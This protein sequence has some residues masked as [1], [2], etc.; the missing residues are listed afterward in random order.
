MLRGSIARRYAEAVFQIG[1]ENNAVDR[2]RDDLRTI[3]EYYG[4]KRLLFVLSEP[5]I[6][7]QRKEQVV[8]DLLADKVQPEAL[9]LAL[10]LVERELAPLG[11][12]ISQAFD[13]RFNDYKGIAVAQVTTAIP[14]DESLRTQIRQQLSQL[15]GKQIQLQERVSPD[16]LG[17]AIAR[18]GDTLIDGSLRRRFELLRQQIATGDLGGPDDGLLAAVLGPGGAGGVGGPDG[19]CGEPPFVVGPAD[20]ETNG[21]GGAAGEASG[22]GGSAPGGTPSGPASSTEMAPRSGSGSAHLGPRPEQQQQRPKQPPQRAGG[23]PNP[24][25]GGNRPGGRNKRRRR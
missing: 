17:G 4:N 5:K 10:L 25:A 6:S 11:P 7:A 15:T 18:V 16:I 2:W 21:G 3:A 13:Q 8:R 19:A 12:A 23:Q 20:T 22:N 1:V 9:N 24:N 14:L